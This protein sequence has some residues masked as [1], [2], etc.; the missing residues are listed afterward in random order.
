MQ[1]GIL[2]VSLIGSFFIAATALAESRVP[3]VG[4]DSGGAEAAPGLPAGSRA[5]AGS[6]IDSDGDGLSDGLNAHLAGLGG[7][8][9]VDVLVQTD[10]PGLASVLQASVGP[11][12]VTH[13]YSLVDGFAA[14]V[15]AGQARA[16]A[17]QAGVTR[18]D[19]DAEATAFLEAA[20]RDFGI[21]DLLDHN[22]AAI[23]GLTGA[24]IT[25]CVIDT[26]IQG[27]HEQFYDGTGSRIDAFYDFTDGWDA[28][29][30]N[31]GVNPFEGIYDDH[32]VGHGTHVAGILGGDG[33]FG[34]GTGADP[35]I[36]PLAMGGAPEV[37]L[38]VAKVLDYT[39]NGPD[40]DIVAAIEWCVG[41][42]P[43]D[44][45]DSD[46]INLSLGIASLTD[47][48]DMLCV[49]V[50]AAV[51]AGVVV[52]AAAGNGGDA[53]GTIG[54]P[55][56]SPKAIT[57]GA[58]AEFSANPNDPW[59]S[60][61]LH[62]TI[63]SS[64]GPG[65]GEIVKP[66]LLGPGSSILSARNAI[67][68][69]PEYLWVVDNE[70]GEGCYGILDGTSQ[71]SPYVAAVAVLMKQANPGLTPAEIKQI[72]LDTAVDRLVAGPDLVSGHGVVDAAAAVTTAAALANNSI[73]VMVND[74]PVQTVGSETIETNGSVDLQI[75]VDDPN[76]PLA[77]TLAI[78]GELACKL[79]FGGDCLV[80]EWDPDLD[81][82]LSDRTGK[83]VFYSGCPAEGDNPFCFPSTPIAYGQLE[84]LYIPTPTRGPYSLRIY[85]VQDSINNGAG[86]T[87]AYDIS[88]GTLSDGGGGGGKKGGG[89]KGGGGD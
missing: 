46:V 30:F 18:V 60:S 73:G 47:C 59:H 36:A 55:G 29:D 87:V 32:Y 40:S 50:E 62:A 53:P 85:A 14:R 63:F 81:A 52:V 69:D 21:D 25:A 33:S 61:G 24:G 72:L 26:G 79:S 45:P 82:I 44:G 7:N 64:Q 34:S 31:N 17:A 5:R 15:N 86:G 22:R 80:I 71:A 48:S 41:T 49:A 38:R 83:E 76:L 39:G 65:V 28:G 37:R 19:L 10:R 9:Q 67:Y 58:A 56:V 54:S 8:E 57:V 27:D 77:I 78:E 2:A 68:V 6:L 13:S 12:S 16:L 43:E 20:R 74:L 3:Y 51:D 35:D 75:A 84:T 11:F 66:D 1:R 23:S 88:N 89:G 70:C 4:Q 42:T